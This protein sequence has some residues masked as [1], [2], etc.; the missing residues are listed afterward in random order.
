MTVSTV[1]EEFTRLTQPFRGE[2]LAHCYRMLGSVHDAEDLVQ[3]TY[4]RAWRAYGGFERRASLRTWLY[5]IATNACLNALQHSSRRVLPSGLAGPTETDPEL[6]THRRDLPWLT[7]LPDGLVVPAPADPAASDPARI[8]DA[9]QGVRLALVAALQHLPARQRAVL[10]LRE[11]LQWPAA[12]V[13]AQLGT[14]TA[15][16]NSALQR[17]RAQLEQLAPD[18]DR[19]SEPEEP[20]R[21]ALLARYQR[22]FETADVEALLG[23]MRADVTWEMPP[24]PEWFAG[25]DRVGRLLRSRVSPVP[26]DYRLLPATANG[27][28][29]FGVYRRRPDGGFR[30]GILHVLTLDGPQIRAVHAFHDDTLLPLCGLPEELPA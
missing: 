30:G 24:M 1:S 12:D 27:Q 10:V 6:P 8:V 18:L 11:I 14:T 13:A 9:R 23:L 15:A 22:A 16:V 20:E 26:G 19:M 17:A 4:L 2:L 21:R 28:P 3:E 25:L 5:R 29:A 7:A